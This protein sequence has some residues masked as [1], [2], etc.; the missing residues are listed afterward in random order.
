MHKLYELIMP[1]KTEALLYATGSLLLLL[2]M[3]INGWW[4]LLLSDAVRDPATVRSIDGR[5]HDFIADHTSLTNPQLVNGFVWGATAL[6]A[7]SLALA[8]AGFI[9]DAQVHSADLK[10]RN[11]EISFFERLFVRAAGSIGLTLGTILCLFEILPA[12]SARFAAYL[13]RDY[14]IRSLLWI[15]ATTLCLALAVYGL[16]IFCRLAAL[17]VRVF[18]ETID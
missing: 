5:F 8:V 12:L 2:I 6:M 1:T 16:A 14:G 7:L 13:L 4:H 11:G 9:H 3:N 18:S 15:L 17:R 10:T